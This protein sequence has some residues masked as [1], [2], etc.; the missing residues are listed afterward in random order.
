[1]PLRA[2]IPYPS[3][4]QDLV[5]AQAGLVAELI[6]GALYLFSRL[7]GNHAVSATGITAMIGPP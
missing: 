5:D 2:E 7:K 6:D 1:M 4:Y 3:T